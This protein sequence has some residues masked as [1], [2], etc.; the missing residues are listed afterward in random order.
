M[1][2]QCDAEQRDEDAVCGDRGPVLEHAHVYGAV[3]G[4][5]CQGAVFV[6]PIAD[7]AIGVV[8]GVCHFYCL[9]FVVARDLP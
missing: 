4:S 2:C 1:D 7:E 3:L 9:L 8:V 6:G 5:G